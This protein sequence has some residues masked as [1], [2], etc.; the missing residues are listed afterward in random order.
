MI[1]SRRI[2]VLQP[3]RYPDDVE[4]FIA[5]WFTGRP[6]PAA[7]LAAQLRDRP[8]LQQAATV[9][10]ILEFYCIV[11]GDQ[12]PGRR[13]RFYAMV[14]RR[15]LTGRWRGDVERDPDPDACLETLRD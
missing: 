13:A 2:G 5:A 7:D 3:L 6:A 9:P 1:R 10:L 8:A 14:I 15:V 4:P 11:G 12:L